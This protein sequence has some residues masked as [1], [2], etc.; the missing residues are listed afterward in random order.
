MS[1]ARSNKS[2]FLAHTKSKSVIPGWAV[3]LVSS[4][5]CD[6]GMNSFHLVTPPSSTCSLQCHFKWEDRT[7]R[8]TRLTT[9]PRKWNTSLLL[10]SYW[11][12]WV[13]QPHLDLRKLG[14]IFLGWQMFISDNCL[15]WKG[16]GTLWWISS[17]LFYKYASLFTSSVELPSYNLSL[18]FQTSIYM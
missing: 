12:E 2:L 18:T 11:L 14:N 9:S 1:V 4:P 16:N 6:S 13:T 17:H 15:L 8:Y 7:E 3:L 5:S 10:T